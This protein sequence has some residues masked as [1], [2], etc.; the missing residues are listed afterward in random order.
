MIIPGHG[1]VTDYVELA[2]YTTMLSQIRDRVRDLIDD[3]ASLEQVIA[4]RPTRRW[5]GEQGEP[6]NFLNRV[7]ASLTR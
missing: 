7:Y 3:G 4:A 2:D 6:E 5:D 1:A